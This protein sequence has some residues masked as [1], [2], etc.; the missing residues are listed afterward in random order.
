MNVI[1]KF[2]TKVPIF[3]FMIAKC[4]PLKIKYPIDPFWV[5]ANSNFIFWARRRVPKGVFSFVV[6]A[7]VNRFSDNK[8]TTCHG[9]P[10]ARI[11]ERPYPC[12]ALSSW[13]CLAQQG[14]PTN[15]TSR[16]ERSY[17]EV[18]FLMSFWPQTE[19]RR[20]KQQRQVLIQELINA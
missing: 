11:A 10:W 18:N 2:L 16:T 13:T 14:T 3:N 1:K 9:L 7:A 12:S 17:Y 8:E 15:G 5:P 4:A 6:P 20:G 19:K